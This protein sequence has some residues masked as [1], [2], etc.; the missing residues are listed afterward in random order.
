[1]NA[2]SR[3]TTERILTRGDA[4]RERRYCKECGNPFWPS[5]HGQDF[6][7]KSTCRSTFHQRRASRGTQLYDLAMEWR[8]K[9]RKGLFTELCRILDDWLYEDRERAKAHKV[10]RE[11]HRRQLREGR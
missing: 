11:A 3:M 5:R 8:G 4:P 7:P 1:M 10:I 6:C 2:I 9:R